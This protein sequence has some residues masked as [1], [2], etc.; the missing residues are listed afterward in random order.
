MRPT[1][2]APRFGLVVFLIAFAGPVQA[3]RLGVARA[4]DLERRGSYAEAVE[5]YRRVLGENPGDI[6]ALLGL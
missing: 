6:T 3:Q 2:L 5:A 4:F 1:S